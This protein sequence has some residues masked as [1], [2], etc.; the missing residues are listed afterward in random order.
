MMRV[1]IFALS[2]MYL[3]A[4]AG[5][6]PSKALVIESIM[7]KGS[8]IALV[9]LHHY[10]NEKNFF[11][12]NR[13]MYSV[14]ESKCSHQLDSNKKFISTSVV[15]NVEKDFYY[16]YATSIDQCRGDKPIQVV[17]KNV[18]PHNFI[19]WNAKNS[20]QFYHAT[21]YFLKNQLHVFNEYE[22]DHQKYRMLRT[23][24]NPNK[25]SFHFGVK[26]T[27]IQSKQTGGVLET[28]RVDLGNN[29][30]KRVIKDDLKSILF[31]DQEWDLSKCS[32]KK[33]LTALLKE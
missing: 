16:I 5:D 20:K 15:I 13:G 4:Y 9:D 19:E 29:F 27:S 31:C 26:K 10:V 17:F 25:T 8:A 6:I 22:S 1:F 3:K 24:D 32:E 23:Y 18:R 7:P 14:E 28:I 12:L 30:K 2:L 21:Y 33:D 11:E